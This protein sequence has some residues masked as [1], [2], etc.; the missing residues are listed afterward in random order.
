[1]RQPKQIVVFDPEFTPP[2]EVVRKMERNGYIV[3]VANADHVRVMSVQNI[4]G[5]DPIALAAL[6]AIQATPYSAV[7]DEFAKQMCAAL[8]LGTLSPEEAAR[9]ARK[10]PE[11]APVPAFDRSW[12]TPDALPPVSSPERKET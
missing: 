12:S 8:L 1:M 5:G 6:R 10:R 2:P 4:G 7:R 11:T 9:A 3:V